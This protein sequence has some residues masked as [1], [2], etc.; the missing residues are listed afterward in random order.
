MSREHSSGVGHSPLRDSKRAGLSNAYI[1]SQILLLI[2]QNLLG[3]F[4]EINEICAHAR[5]VD[6][7]LSFPPPQRPGYEANSTMHL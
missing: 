3:I 7:R 2:Q 1:R 4:L 6:T 5:T